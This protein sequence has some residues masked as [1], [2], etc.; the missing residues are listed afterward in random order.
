MT[1]PR[2]PSSDRIN[3]S[4]LHCLLPVLVLISPA[5]KG[6]EI[7]WQDD[8]Q[9]TQEQ[10]AAGKQ[11]V[12]IAVN[13]DGERANDRLVKETYTSD[14]IREL[15]GHTLNLV[16][17]NF[18]HGS[19]SKPCPR[20]GTITCDEHRHVDSDVRA[21]ILSPDERGF[22][23]APQH[24]FLS[25]EGEVILSVPYDLKTA[26]LEWCF[27]HALRS[28]NPD[29]KLE[30][31][32]DARPPK[33]LMMG[34]V[35]ALGS[36]EAAEEQTP[37]TREAALELIKDLK[38]GLLKNQELLAAVRRLAMADEPEAREY[39][40]QL[41]RKAPGRKGA[42]GANRKDKRSILMHWIGAN[43]PSS[44]W[45]VVIEFIGD[46]DDAIRGEAIVAIEQLGDRGAVKAMTSRLRKE[47]EPSAQKNILRAIGTCAADDRG[48]RTTLI[49]HAK[50]KR[51]PLMRVNAIVALGWLSKHK[52]IDEFLLDSL[53]SEFE[54]VQQ[55]AALAMA[56]SR[57]QSW[58]E[59]LQGELG[60]AQTPAYE[61]VLKK[62]L[63]VLEGGALSEIRA[64]VQELCS[65]EIE[66][67]RI[68][69]A[70]KGKA[71]R[72]GGERRE[73]G[74]SPG[75]SRGTPD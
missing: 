20:F 40:L 10:A 9:R 61:D 56:I 62:A 35:Y 64:A 26:E 27:V 8:L 17:S 48:A 30:L 36:A 60:G 24:V 22:V 14:S 12:F 5:N 49:K 45:E 37:L 70:S 54:D 6:G 66:R 75:G 4:L 59:I 43:S 55:A 11:V 21:K 52:D 58:T 41:L 38:K 19:S 42:A 50:S 73:D 67:E 39:C 69:G 31:S 23:V 51:E 46:N 72:R 33:R 29:L 57:D 71:R 47:K 25:P 18:E 3:M 32:S 15:A 28:N 13:M 53:G 7:Q 74:D 2:I 16:A 1:S 63:A 68:F 44:Y 34:D 65:D